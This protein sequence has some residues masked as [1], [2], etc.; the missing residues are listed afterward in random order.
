MKVDLNVL[1]NA[2]ESA[3][4]INYN[5]GYIAGELAMLTEIESYIHQLKQ[6]II[7]LSTSQT[8]LN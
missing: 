1:E 5:I 3:S 6:N 8:N 7:S 2:I 4:N